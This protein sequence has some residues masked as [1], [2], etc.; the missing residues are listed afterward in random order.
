MINLNLFRNIF[1]LTLELK[2]LSLLN[3]LN[4]SSTLYFKP[5]ID[6]YY[7]LFQFSIFYVSSSVLIVL[8][9]ITSSSLAFK[10]FR[11]L[12]QILL[13]YYFI[14]FIYCFK[15]LLVVIVSIFFYKLCYQKN[16]NFILGS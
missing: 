8:F 3:K 7:R 14:I 15:L 11:F 9:L 12:I 6:L 16:L 2:I 5:M 1:L 4:F 10:I 13:Q